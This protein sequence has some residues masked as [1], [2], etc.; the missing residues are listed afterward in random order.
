MEKRFNQDMHPLAIEDFSQ[1]ASENG[2]RVQ[3]TYFRTLAIC[4]WLLQRTA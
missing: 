2:F 3:K 1:L 4:G